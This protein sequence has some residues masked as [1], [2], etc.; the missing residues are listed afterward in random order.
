MG[1]RFAEG[2]VAVVAAIGRVT[3]ETLYRDPEQWGDLVRAYIV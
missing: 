1:S 2:A 3:G